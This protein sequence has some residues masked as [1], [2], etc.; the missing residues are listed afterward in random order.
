MSSSVAVA[1]R[2]RSRRCASAED[3]YGRVDLLR[4]R[5]TAGADGEGTRYT[6][7][8]P[9]VTA[10]TGLGS[11]ALRSRMTNTGHGA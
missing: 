5:I 9:V 7:T 4:K 8:A 10:G 3:I 11:T 6:T 2:R 1:V